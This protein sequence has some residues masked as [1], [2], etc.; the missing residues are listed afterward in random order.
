M[1]RR[2]YGE[3]HEKDPMMIERA[4]VTL[5][6]GQVHL[7]RRDAPDARGRPLLMLHASPVS[8]WVFQGL[9]EAIAAVGAPR[10][11]IAPD[12]L[13]N[14]DS[15]PPDRDAPDIA[16]FAESQIRLM[17]ALGIDRVDVSGSHTGARIAC[18]LAAAYP[19]RVGR[20]IFDGIIEYD[21]AMR[22]DIVEHYAPRMELDAYGGYLA[23]AF[24][25][26]RDQALYFPYFKRDPEH[27]LAGAMP[28][29]DVLHRA[30]LDVLKALGTY[31]KPYIA[32]FEYRAYERM[33]A[34]KA[35]VLLLKP[36]T[37][38]PI[39]NAA[40]AT[41]AGLLKRAEI[42]SVPIGDAAKAAAMARFLDR[43]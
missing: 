28:P 37:E 40:I 12:T 20:V 32:A 14:G 11:L 21:D 7:R 39:L 30:V 5:K 42:A 9:M 24:N 10:T 6:E 19:D 29:P 43:P 13:G 34:I 17:D 38:L 35:P 15:A 25:F 41:A 26:V 16:Y 36:D 2:V 23:W 31:S 4:F 8:S 3:R 33:P 27:R 18:E 1:A 22:R